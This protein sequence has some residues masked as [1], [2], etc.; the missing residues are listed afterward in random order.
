MALFFCRGQRFFW[1]Y[2]Y[3]D[4]DDSLVN[5]TSLVVCFVVLWTLLVLLFV[6]YYYEK[7]IYLTGSVWLFCVL[8][9]YLILMMGLLVGD[10]VQAG[11][12]E[13]AESSFYFSLYQQGMLILTVALNIIIT[14]V[15][16]VD[17]TRHS[18]GV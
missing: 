4:R 1:A 8:A 14:T 6:A 17:T 16:L 7:S 2:W 10:R 11:Y 13:E 9:G 12:M 15:A 18:P 5:Q 3:S